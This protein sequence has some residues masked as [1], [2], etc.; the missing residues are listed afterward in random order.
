[1]IFS[2]SAGYALQT[3][4]YLSNYSQGNPVSQ[5]NLSSSLN[6]PFHYLGKILQPLTKNKI[7]DSK[8]GGNGG[9][10]LIKSPK[11]IVLCD[12]IFLFG[13][14]DCFDDCIIGFPGCSDS[15][16]CPLHDNN[17]GV[18]GCSRLAYRDLLVR[19]P[20]ATSPSRP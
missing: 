7:I 16:P 12:I 6:I 11:E 18:N 8:K 14:T 10:Y 5:Q 19:T 13:E 4:I 15:S 20:R 1:M 3:V 2:K 17:S 9:F